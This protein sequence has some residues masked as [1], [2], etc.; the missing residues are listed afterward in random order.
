MN[1]KFC[2]LQDGAGGTTLARRNVS[3]DGPTNVRSGHQ[4]WTDSFGDAWLMNKEQAEEIA[5]NL[6]YNN[7]RFSSAEKA[8]KRMKE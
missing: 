8:Q 1:S 3:G 5:G 7:P 6:F 2:V 4:K